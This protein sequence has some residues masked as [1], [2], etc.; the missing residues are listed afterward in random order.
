M[1]KDGFQT[2]STPM[3]AMARTAV[4]AVR[5]V[6]ISQARAATISSTDHQGSHLQTVP[7]RIEDPGGE[8][9]RP[10]GRTADD[11]NARVEVAGHPLDGPVH[12]LGDSDDPAV[13]PLQAVREA[14]GG[15]YGDG[16][17][18]GVR[19][20]R[21]GV[22]RGRLPEACAG[23]AGHPVEDD[24]EQHDR[25]A[26]GERGTHVDRGERLVDAVAETAGA[27]HG[28]DDGH[29]QRHHDRLV[30]PEEEFLAG[31]RE[32]GGQQALAGGGPERVDR[33]QH[34]LV[35]AAQAERGEAGHGRG[36]VDDGG[37]DGGG[38]A[39]A[40]D[41]DDGEEVGERREDLHGVEDRAQDA[42]HTAGQAGGEA[43]EGTHRDGRGDR[44]GHQGEGLHRGDPHAEEAAGEEG[45]GGAEG[46]PDSRRAPGDQGGH[47]GHSGPAD[48]E[49]GEVDGAYGD[50]DGV[51]DVA[52]EVEE[53]GWVSL[54]SM[55]Q[56]L[57]VARGRR[58][59]W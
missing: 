35:G 57:V 12:R 23:R 21:A 38:D 45:G 24:G 2:P 43:E 40:E 51:A 37:E 15:R 56:S 31:Q 39:D 32:P 58:G 7:E 29:G 3:A 22:G 8:A 1:S 42:V 6:P 16:G 48:G 20:Q 4:S 36:G 11:G 54:L 55:I 41:Q 25:D 17:D 27:D 26:G 9:A 50:D 49:E 14:S 30:E 33:L 5:H 13:G 44:Y 52:Q 34:L 10:V 19:P 28:G 46:E 47:G 18:P 59:R 53:E